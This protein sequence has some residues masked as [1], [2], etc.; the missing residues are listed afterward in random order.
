MCSQYDVSTLHK[1]EVYD[2]QIQF[3][4]LTIIYPYNYLPLFETK[5]EASY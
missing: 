5:S 4:L 2:Q 3:H 1:V